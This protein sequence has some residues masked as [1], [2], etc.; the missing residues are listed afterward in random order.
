MT[1]KIQPRYKLRQEGEPIQYKD[2]VLILNVKLNSFVNFNTINPIPLD[3][4]IPQ[5]E[6]PYYR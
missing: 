6:K 4:P 1:F 3:K 5:Q 2:N